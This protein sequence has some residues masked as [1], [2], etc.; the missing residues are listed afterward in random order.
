MQFDSAS[1]NADAAIPT[2]EFSLA[3]QNGAL[4][5]WRNLVRDETMSI[6]MALDLLLVRAGYVFMPNVRVSSLPSEWVAQRVNTYSSN[7]YMRHLVAGGTGNFNIQTPAASEQAFLREWGGAE[8]NLNQMSSQ[9]ELHFPARSKECAT[10]YN[11]VDETFCP[12]RGLNAYRQQTFSLTAVINSPKSLGSGS[13][14]ARIMSDGAVAPSAADPH[15][16]ANFAQLLLKANVIEDGL[17]RKLRVPFGR[18]IYGG[19]HM[20]TTGMDRATQWTQVCRKYAGSWCWLTITNADWNDWLLG[21][22]DNSSTDPKDMV[23]ASG[24]V[25][26]YRNEAGMLRIDAA[27]PVTR[28]FPAR[29][30]GASRINATSGNA[31]WQWTYD[32]V[33]VEPKKLALLPLTV[34]Q[35]DYGRHSATRGVP[36]KN[37]CENGNV[38]LGAGAAGNVIAPGVLQS[39]YPNATVEPAPI[40]NDTVVMMC[41]QATNSALQDIPSVYGLEYWF[42]MPNAV[43]TTCIGE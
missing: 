13:Y 15:I 16:E 3:T 33:E 35:D 25:Q 9:A 24:L 27:P 34:D 14:P 21:P 4:L 7:N 37:L 22:L 41:E 39:D 43:I 31:Y 10:Y 17:E 1:I 8:W 29:I 2:G 18:R 5:T 36:A 28:V 19:I 6:G 38:Y 40:C 26:A 42:A 11:N 23:L 32:F 30:T 12:T 20:V